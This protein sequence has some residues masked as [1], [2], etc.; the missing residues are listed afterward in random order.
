MLAWVRAALV[1]VALLFVPGLRDSFEPPRAAV[2]RA[3]GL[4]LLVYVAAA[5]RRGAAPRR[6]GMDAAI[7]AWLAIEVLATLASRSPLVSAI[8]EPMQREGLV[9]PPGRAGWC[10]APPA[11]HGGAAPRAQ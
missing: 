3:A 7:A 9:T 6:T 11:T 1:R 2:V 4:A 8:G 5:G 10:A